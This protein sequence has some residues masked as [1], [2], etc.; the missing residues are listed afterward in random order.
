MSLTDPR[1]LAITAA[2]VVPISGTS[3]YGF[4]PGEPKLAWMSRGFLWA[5]RMRADGAR[6]Q[7]ARNQHDVTNLVLVLKPLAQTGK[8][9]A[10]DVYYTE[11]GQQYQQRYNSAVK[12][13]SARFCHDA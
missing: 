8:A 11:S 3:L 2:W 1:S 13:T 6:V 4:L 9:S 12:L 5:K 7:P 10:I